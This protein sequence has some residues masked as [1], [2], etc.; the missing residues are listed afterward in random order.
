MGGFDLVNLPNVLKLH[1]LRFWADTAFL[2]YVK[3]SQSHC[4][5]LV[6]MCSLKSK[7]KKEKT[8]QK[9]QYKKNSTKKETKLFIHSNMSKCNQP[10]PPLSSWC[11][12]Q[13]CFYSPCWKEYRPSLETVSTQGEQQTVITVRTKQPGTHKVKKKKQHST[14]QCECYMNP[15]P[16]T[17]SNINQMEF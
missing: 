6:K 14:A 5:L 3:K 9:K 7:R 16:K 8:V 12:L 17:L 10:F 1:A 15:F 11:K 4:I 13:T 2:S